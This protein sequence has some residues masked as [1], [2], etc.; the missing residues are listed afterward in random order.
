MG[1]KKIKIDRTKPKDHPPAENSF[2]PSVVCGLL[3]KLGHEKK[4]EE[5]INNK[6]GI[7]LRKLSFYDVQI[8]VDD[9]QYNK[10]MN[11]IKPFIRGILAKGLTLIPFRKFIDKKLNKKGYSFISNEI[12]TRQTEPN[13]ELK[14]CNFAPL[15]FDYHNLNLIRPDGKPAFTDEEKANIKRLKTFESDNYKI[16]IMGKMTD[17]DLIINGDDLK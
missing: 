16:N 13:H 7:K 8:P 11:L 2:N 15:F 4:F 1:S 14:S 17:V 10:A 6:H 3:H 9:E 5:Y 12:F